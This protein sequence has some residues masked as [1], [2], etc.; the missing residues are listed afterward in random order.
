MLEGLARLEPRAR[1]SC[2]N[3]SKDKGQHGA[4]LSSGRFGTG[5]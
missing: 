2:L 1:V 3:S 5:A 4:G